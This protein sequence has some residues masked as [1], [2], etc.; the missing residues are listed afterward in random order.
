M[1]EIV[2][3]KKVFENGFEAL[4]S[5]D[6]TIEKGDLVCLLGPS[7]C[8]KSTILNMIAGLL[9]PTEGDIRFDGKS[10][11]KTEPKDRNIGFVFQNYALYPH[12]TVEENVMFPLTVGD[13]KMKKAEAKPIAE[14]YMK[15]TNIEEL[16]DKKPG[17]LSGGQQQRVAITRA[18]VQ[19]PEVLLLDE[20]L[21]NLDAR[22]R[23]KIREEIRRLVK[24]VGIT[25]IFV[26]HD[27][28]EALSISDKIILLNEGVVQ[29]DDDPQNLYLEPSNLFVAKFIGNPIINILPVEIKD[30]QMLHPEFSIPLERFSDERFKKG[31]QDG[32]YYIGIRPEDVIPADVEP[33]F[34]A[35]IKSVELIGR[36]RILN[37]D[38]NE[39]HSKSLVP[40]EVAI[41]E[42]NT[43][44]F[45]FNLNK[46][47][48]FEKEG[49]R[50]Y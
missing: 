24:E 19:N 15:L 21:S 40:I 6:F 39:I 23:L 38:V 37:F 5:V 33:D 4:K 3:L 49:A 44:G 36:E 30:G 1:I 10:V 50:I 14:K 47:F 43:Q 46:A 9:T 22:L 18:L 8:G 48:I 2:G 34:T 35:N 17:T 13:K 45:R 32:Q 42:G 25:T 26:T 20:P 11:V 27:Q 7:G 28:E 29:Q 12:M 31:Y 41:E 16:K